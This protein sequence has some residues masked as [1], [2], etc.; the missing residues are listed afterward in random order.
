MSQQKA[1]GKAEAGP[2]C[3]HFTAKF[4][5]LMGEGQGKGGS[6][7]MAPVALPESP[8]FSSCFS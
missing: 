1:F 2:L 4:M 8:D 3:R 5:P 6:W 7:K